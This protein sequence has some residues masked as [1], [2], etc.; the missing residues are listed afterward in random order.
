M[1]EEDGEGERRR[2]GV[3]KEPRSQPEGFPNDQR[4]NITSVF[5]ITQRVF[6]NKRERL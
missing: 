4:W 3:L 5:F 6:L 1:E 2:R